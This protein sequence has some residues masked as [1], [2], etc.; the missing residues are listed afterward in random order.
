MLYFF[1]SYSRSDDD[2]FVR[3]FFADL[4]REVRVRVGAERDEVVGFLDNQNINLGEH[5]PT[6]LVRALAECAS[7]LPLYSPGYFLSRPCGQEWT[8]FAQR[9][10]DDVHDGSVSP[11]GLIPLIWLPPRTLPECARTLH[12][13]LA[14]PDDEYSRRGIRQLLRLKRLR[15]EYTEF[16]EI[17]A[18]HVVGAADTAPPRGSLEIDFEHLASAFDPVPP[19]SSAAEEVLN[20]LASGTQVIHFVMVAPTRA[21]AEVIGRNPLYYGE[22]SSDWAPFRPDQPRPLWESV[23][24]VATGQ[25]L[26]STVRGVDRLND[27]LKLAEDHNHLV[28]LLIDAWSVELERYRAV[29]DEFDHRDHRA[30]VLIVMSH[31]D[32]ETQSKS[33]FLADRI[34]RILFNTERRLDDMMLRRSVLAG[35]SFESD[36]QVVLTEARNRLFAKGRVLRQPSPETPPGPRPILEGP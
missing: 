24:K 36:L 30:A 23:Q 35:P 14:V 12:Y 5:W 25:E 31:G 28:V 17:V 7:F 19:E 6:A 20:P 21:E 15:D 16:V 26:L 32:P 27:C 4:S 2:M 1:L 3:R 33:S 22:H 8:M 9:S 29:L 34:H 18:Q 10:M 11:P 13:D